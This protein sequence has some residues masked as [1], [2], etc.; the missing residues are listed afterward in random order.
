MPKPSDVDVPR[1]SSSTMTSDFS[2]AV[3]RMQAAS[4]ISAM[5]VEIPRSCMSEAP[6]RHMTASKIGRTALWQGTKLPIWFSSTMRATDR[7]YVLFPPMLGPVMMCRRESSLSM[8]TSFA[9][10]PFSEFATTS[11]WAAPRTVKVLDAG[12][13][14]ALTN[15]HG[16]VSATRAKAARTSRSPR[17]SPKRSTTGEYVAATASALATSCSD[18]RSYSRIDSRNC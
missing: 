1:P 5:K 17:T 18:C 3:L 15:E 14:R 4:S 12:S 16:A 10:N 9:T 6:T 2:V 7:M 11:T 8:F 13:T